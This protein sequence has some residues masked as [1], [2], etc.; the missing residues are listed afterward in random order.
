MRVFWDGKLWPPGRVAF[1]PLNTGLFFGESLFEA[2]P[3]YK[4]KALFLEDHLERLQRGCRFLGWPFPRIGAFKKAIQ[5]FAETWKEEAGFM[6]RFNLFQEL[7]LKAGPRTFLKHMPILFA[8]SRSLRH[9]PYSPLPP[10]GRVGLSPWRAPHAGMVPNGF[11]LASY[12]SIRSV[13]R[14]NPQ[15]DEILRLNDRGEV[16]DGGAST[17]LWFDGKKIWAPPLKLGG[18]ES[19]TRKR[20]IQLSS[21]LGIQAIS[22]AWKPKDIFKKGELFLSGPEWD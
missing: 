1:S 6:V 7:G 8:T 9:D 19:V 13:F 3:V 22:K 5:L 20:I 14:A 12:V 10:E 2:V 21:K 16:V 18:L 17:P 11:K 15:W 4:D